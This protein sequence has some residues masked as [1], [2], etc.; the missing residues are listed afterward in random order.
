MNKNLW[1]LDS[2]CSEHM[3]GDFSKFSIFTKK[4]R[5]FVTFRDNTKARSM[6]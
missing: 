1:L 4:D 5:G 6:I 2:E 3:V